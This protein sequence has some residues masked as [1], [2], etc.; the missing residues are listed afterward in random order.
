VDLVRALRKHGVPFE[1]IVI[2]DEIHDLLLYRSWL[3]LFHATDEFFDRK[4]YQIS[5][6]TR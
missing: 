1:Q 4:L 2:P 6:R 5:S 3:M